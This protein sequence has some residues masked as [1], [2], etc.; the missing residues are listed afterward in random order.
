M[1]KM[2]RASY[3]QKQDK[4]KKETKERLEK[5]RKE[6]AA[7]ENKKSKKL[8][9]VKKEVFRHRSKAQS[10]NKKNSDGT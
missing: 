9:Q 5:H 8:Q 10:R 1:M 2:L 7:V 4:L 3:E 6:I